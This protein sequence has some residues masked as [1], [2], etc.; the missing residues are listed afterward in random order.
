[1]LAKFWSD[2]TAGGV[3]EESGELWSQDGQLLLQSRQLAVLRMP[4]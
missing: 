2:R 1:V 4:S 3:F